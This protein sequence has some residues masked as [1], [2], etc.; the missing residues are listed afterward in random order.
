M[1]GNESGVLFAWGQSWIPKVSIFLIGGWFFPHTGF[2]CQANLQSISVQTLNSV[3]LKTVSLWKY[4]QSDL[5]VAF[6]RKL[7]RYLYVSPVL[8]ALKQVITLLVSAI[9]NPRKTCVCVCVC[10]RARACTHIHVTLDTDYIDWHL[11]RWTFENSRILG[12]LRRVEVID[13]YLRQKC[14]RFLQCVAPFP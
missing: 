1:F 2:L 12:P 3:S 10:V 4:V 6:Q 7:L 9:Q 13:F 5:V 14:K 11:I 8:S